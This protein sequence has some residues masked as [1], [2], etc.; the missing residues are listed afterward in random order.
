MTIVEKE[1]RLNI[2]LS[3]R[4]WDKISALAGKSTCRSLSEYARKVLLQ[5]PVKIFYRNATFDEFE[6]QMAG[7]LLPTLEAFQDKF[8]TFDQWT[9]AGALQTHLDF[10]ETAAEISALLAKFA[11]QCLPK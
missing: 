3:Q 2:R 7:R 6:D 8:Q 11:D 5:Q 1:H 10:L 9:T 4:D